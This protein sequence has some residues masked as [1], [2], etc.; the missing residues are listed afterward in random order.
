MASAQSMMQAIMKTAIKAAKL[1]N[2]HS[3]KQ[4]PQPKFQG[5][6]Q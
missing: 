6:Y 3:Q 5:E 1:K 2:N 4:R